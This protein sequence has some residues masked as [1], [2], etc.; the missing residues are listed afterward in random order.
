M[1]V[2]YWTVFGSHV[3][4]SKHS[5]AKAAERAAKKCE[6]RGGFPH[7]ILKVQEIKRQRP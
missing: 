4:C 1:K 2:E 3:F 7:R 6:K 5:T